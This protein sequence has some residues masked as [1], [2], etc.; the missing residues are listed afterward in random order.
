VH[1]N[2]L[3]L[4]IGRAFD[5]PNLLC[6]NADKALFSISI[7][8]MIVGLTYNCV[9]DFGIDSRIPAQSNKSMPE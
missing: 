8:D 1:V 7:A 3:T 5:F 9:S 2:N 4:K 6:D